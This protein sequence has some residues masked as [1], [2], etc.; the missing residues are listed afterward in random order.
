MCRSYP[1]EPPHPLIWRRDG[2][3]ITE[4]SSPRISLNGSHQAL[5]IS[6]IQES[7]SGLYQC[8]Y[9]TPEGFISADIQVQ[10]I[11]L[12]FIVIEPPE[13]HINVRFNH[14][15]NITCNARMDTSLTYY[16]LIHSQS[17]RMATLFSSHT[18]RSCLGSTGA[19]SYRQAWNSFVT[20]HW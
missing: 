7:D 3:V 19:S 9:N 1:G 8:G 13:P 10:V 5:E 12:P 16:W 6:N 17:G 14:S 11:A 4:A 18:T 20:Q 2:N 15:L